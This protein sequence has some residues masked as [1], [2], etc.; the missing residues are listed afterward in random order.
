VCRADV[1][2]VAY[3]AC[4]RNNGAPGCD[5]TTFDQIISHGQDRWLEELRQELLA[6]EYRPQPLLRV[7]IPKITPR[8]AG[9]IAPL[10]RSLRRADLLPRA[11]ND[12]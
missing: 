3:R 12:A 6:G 9:R 10:R 11:A 8:G 1:L 4:H 5:G 2:E 7:W